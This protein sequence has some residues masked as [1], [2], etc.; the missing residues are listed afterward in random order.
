M[1]QYRGMPELGGR[2]EWVGG[3]WNTLI[4]AG[5]RRMSQGVFGRETRK[6]ENI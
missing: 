3:W 2:T 5:K 6:V 4:E 1:P